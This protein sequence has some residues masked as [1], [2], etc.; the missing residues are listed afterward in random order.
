MRGG[1]GGGAPSS[2]GSDCVDRR[3]RDDDRDN[4]GHRDG[5]L[6]FRKCGQRRKISALEAFQLR[7][8]RRDL[9]VDI[10]TSV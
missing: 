5:D 7:R 9:E 6:G 4:G 10:D 2:L 8:C 3:D 1:A